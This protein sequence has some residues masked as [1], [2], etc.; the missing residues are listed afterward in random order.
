MMIKYALTR[1]AEEPLL[2]IVSPGTQVKT[3]SAD[4]MS[5]FIAG[6]QPDPAYT[7]VHCVA[8]GRSEFYGSNS[9]NDWYG[10]N[11]HLNIDGLLHAWDGIGIDPVAD[12]LKGATWPY[13]YPC[14]YNAAAYAHHK[15]TDPVQLGFG[16]VVFAWHN[17]V[18]KR[19]ELIIRVFNAEARD[20]GHD[21][22][23]QKIRGG[24]R[25]D[26]SMG[27]KIPF[28]NCSVC[29]DWET[30]RRAM[31]TFD[32]TRHISPG[33]AILEWHRRSPIRGLAVTMAEHCN[34]M[35]LTRG[36]I[37]PD[38]RKIFVYNDFVRFFDISFVWIGADKTARVMWHLSPGGPAQ[39]RT[40]MPGAVAET[41]RG[42]S[43]I[44]AM[45]KEIPGGIISSV[46]ND[47]ASSPEMAFPAGANPLDVLSG[48]A[49][50]GV[51]ATPH[52]FQRLTTNCCSGMTPCSSF[53]PSAGATDYSFAVGSQHC[54]DP[55]LQVLAHS[56]GARSS[57]APFLG[58]RL[59]S[60]R[61]VLEI[62]ISPASSEKVA[63]QYRGY[64]VSLLENATDLFPKVANHLD[65]DILL[66]EKRSG[67]GIGGLLLGLAPVLSLLS[68]HF[69][70]DEGSK[71]LNAM[72]Q[73]IA[74]HPSL[75]NLAKIGNGLR[76]ALKTRDGSIGAAAG[77]LIP[78]GTEVF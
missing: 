17:T 10:Y 67:L 23:L 75:Q 38:G 72:A 37:L 76:W 12:K 57:F 16:D 5:L 36:K 31:A 15:N 68:S 59:V 53:D 58:P 47:A 71:N 40:V 19:I 64:R 21:G 25:C 49:A 18:M 3:A 44:A 43:K 14:F 51:V 39:R 74:D 61:K 29:S 20:K 73:L 78:Q 55:V 62:K 8:M 63:G 66:R 28:D 11:P 56:L 27:T 50:L 65:T 4:A 54:T 42:M 70:S 9:N 60:P 30:V 34:C 33:V 2:H 77:L 69:S 26:V 48:M 32:P 13:G 7:Y 22:I 52:E 46:N 41:I 35:K 45:E 6:L 24:L 1:G